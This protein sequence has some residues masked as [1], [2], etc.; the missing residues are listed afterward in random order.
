MSSIFEKNTQYIAFNDIQLSDYE[1]ALLKGIKEGL[2]E[3]Q[4]ICENKET[5]NFN[6][7]ILALE[8]SGSLLN[9]VTEV[10]F[11]LNS[12]VTN[13]EMQELAQ[14]FSPL[15][16]A[17][18]NDIALN[19]AL[20]DRV[21]YVYDH[22]KDQKLDT[23]DLML[24]EKSYKGFS[25][26]GALLNEADKDK[27]RKLD[28]EL[29]MAQLKFGENVLAENN[30]YEL[31][32]TDE[33]RLKGIPLNAQ[34]SAQE[35]AK[36]KE[37]EGY[38]FTLDYPSYLPVITYAQDRA[39]REEL[40]RASGAK[41]FK[42]NPYN[43][44]KLVLRIV[45][46]R[47]ER[48]N[49]LGYNTHAD[50]VLE[51]RMAQD[52]KTVLDFLDQILVAAKP[53]AAS[54]LE[55]L[56]ELAKKDGIQELQKWDSSYYAEK[57]K[58]QKFDFDQEELR[59]YF[60]LDKVIDGVFEV[61]TK[62]YGL[63]FKLNAQI[64]KY[65]PDVLCYDVFDGDQ[66]IATFYADYF[67]RESKR[68]GA[69]MTSYKGQF[70]REDKKQNPVVS[71][72]CNFTKPTQGTP[73]LLTFDEV[74]TLFHEFGHALHGLLA[75]SKYESISG[76][77]VYWDFVELPS[78]ILE[79][80]CYQKECLDLFARHHETNQAIPQKFIQKIKEA[81]HFNSGLQ[82]VRQVGLSLVDMLWHTQEGTL[83]Q[84]VKEFEKE[85]LKTTNVLPDIPE[86]NLSCQFSHIFQ[87]GYSSGYYS[88][89]WAEVLAA[90]AFE[91]FLE[92]GVFD[93]PTAHQFK[94]HILSAGGSEH[95]MTLY[96]R[97]RGQEPDV[98]ALLRSTGLVSK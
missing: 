36:Q 51:L 3:I 46:L 13:K 32:L 45:E 42:D 88:Y 72:V 33:N 12:C 90:D 41:A 17:Y 1:P 61:A 39:L 59:P 71:I 7:T 11:N 79:N 19:Q 98:N 15:L 48:A 94:Q 84:S 69:W 63:S 58:K 67:P 82:T 37:K 75:N 83:A 16:S 25:R 52:K 85:A 81:A 24:L 89:K 55:E 44:E 49:L 68:Q 5:A 38:I 92:K 8:E 35:L 97:F 28:E 34:Q 18:Q 47:N 93:P 80:W 26:N 91:L 14:K 76:T 57:L 96:K 20:F 56:K 95:P 27:L 73:S 70:K 66:E 87:G 53:F 62:L 6:N 21:K 4:L 43:N 30:A 23:Q 60:Q 9:R 65:H 78:Q 10:F 86:S 31:H 74:T 54:E 50:Y 22:Q 2:A 29:S 77:S 64:P 40:T